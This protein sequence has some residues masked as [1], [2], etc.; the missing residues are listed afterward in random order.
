MKLLN[1]VPKNLLVRLLRVLH[2]LFHQV[3]GLSAN[4]CKH[5]NT[6]AASSI[7][8][9]LESIHTTLVVMSLNKICGGAMRISI[10]L[11]IG[12]Y[13][14]IYLQPTDVQDPIVHFLVESDSKTP[15]CLLP[16][17]PR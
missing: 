17:I 16:K 13:V 8:Y 11:V 2:H 12:H 5:S 6:N 10:G 7:S 1:L 9:T 15:Q 4:E 3:E 14:F